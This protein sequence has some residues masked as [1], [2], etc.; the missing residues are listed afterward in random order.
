MADTLR[1]VLLVVGISIVLAST[2]GFIFTVQKAANC[3]FTAVQDRP[4]GAIVTYY[5]ELTPAG[6]RLF[7]ELVNHPGRAYRNPNCPSGL[8][9]FGGRYYTVHE[10][11]TIVWSHPP[12]VG[13]LLGVLLGASGCYLAIRPD[14]QAAG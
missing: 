13:A 2:A 1:F 8:V 7:L 5:S 12:T 14:L 3:R 10:W 11:G 4:N 9:R 6:Q